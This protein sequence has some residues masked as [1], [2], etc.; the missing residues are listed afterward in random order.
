MAR[1]RLGPG[2]RGRFGTSLGSD[3]PKLVSAP[4]KINRPST[5]ALEKPRCPY[6][7]WLDDAGDVIIRGQL[8]LACYLNPSSGHLSITLLPRTEEHLKAGP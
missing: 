8:P 1:P 2:A 7:I 6:P 4:Q 3:D 5:A